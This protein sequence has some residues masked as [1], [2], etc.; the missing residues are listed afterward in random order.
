M[1]YAEIKK[2]I[3]SDFSTPLNEGGVKIVKSVQRGLVMAGTTITGI[4][5]FRSTT[6][7]IYTKSDYIDITISKINLDKCLIV[8]PEGVQGD[9][10]S[11]YVPKM[12]NDTTLRVYTHATDADPANARRYTVWMT[13]TWQIIEFY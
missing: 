13:F 2:T 12:I 8:I 6:G 7:T 5:T 11:I 3:N 10:T 4:K 9:S 1:S